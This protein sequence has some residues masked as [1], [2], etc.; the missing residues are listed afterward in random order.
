MKQLFFDLETTGLD[1]EKHGVHQLSGMIVINGEIKE[2]F[3]FKVQPRAGAL[4]S[5]EALAIA[6]VTVDI[7]RTYKP[8]QDTYNE[9]VAIL[10]KYVDK[11]NKNDKFFLV[12]YNNASF[13]NQ[14][15]RSW[16]TANGDKYF[17]SWFWSNSFD[18]MVLAT[19]YL[20]AKRASMENFKL[21]TVAK[22]CGVQV[23][24]SKLHDADYDIYLTHE[25]YKKVVI[26]DKV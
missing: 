17:G 5:Q 16:F 15:L 19:P 23:D 7:L 21:L 2:T 18:V 3:N 26:V 8:L 12:G 4:V 24:E 1:H 6:N 9:F 11:F 13:D 20:A 22:A 25:V 10:S 14:F